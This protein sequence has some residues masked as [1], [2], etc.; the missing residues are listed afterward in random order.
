MRLSKIALDLT[1]LLTVLFLGFSSVLFFI[2]AGWAGQFFMNRPLSLY[3]F[4][5]VTS[6]IL[7]FFLAYFFLLVHKKNT[8]VVKFEPKRVDIDIA[9]VK[10]YLE[11]SFKNLKI[12]CLEIE[13]EVDHHHKMHIHTRQEKLP[14]IHDLDRIE[15]ELGGMLGS[16]LGYAKDFQVYFSKY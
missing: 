9:I 13:I 5:G 15:K 8:L 14:N 7:A 1:T 3:L 11:K 2:D 12:E 6:L 4:L 16:K 10:S